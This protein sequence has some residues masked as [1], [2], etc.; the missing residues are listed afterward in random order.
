[1][2]RP[3][4][5]PRTI[6]PR[7]HLIAAGR[8]YPEAWHRVDEM[9]R[10]RGHGLPSWPDW[11]YIPITGTMAIVA[12]DARISVMDMGRLY[13]QRVPDA[14]RLAAL[15]AWRMTQGI[16]RFDPAVYDAVRS[17]PVTGDIPH[18]VLYR[19][20]EWCVYI[21]TPGLT[22]GAAPMA[23]AWA[24]LEHDI[25]TGRAELRL[26]IDTDERAGQAL[27]PALLHLGPW[28][29]AESISRALDVVGVQAMAHGHAPPQGL[30]GVLQPILEPLV[31]LTLY[32]CSQAAEIGDGSRQP[33][34]PAPKRVK[35]GW[36]IFAAEKPTTWD[37]GARMGAALR[38]AYQAT[39][40]GN[41]DTHAG[42]RPH[43]R[44][45]HW[46]GFRSGP[47]LRADGSEIPTEDRA[48]DLRWLPPI[49]V[50]VDAGPIVPTVRPVD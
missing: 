18:Q 24:H 6:R 34:N 39:E 21:E 20:P 4:F 43:V 29:L 32:V 3:K 27:T 47:R 30:R 9:R 40:T 44:R 31:S 45:A 10:E 14:A 38:K 25:N 48:F 2:P 46:H 19:L 17:T 26:L 8:L 50:N 13:P 5:A 12:D 33:G 37:V 42:P 41:G 23:G 22:L 11:C 49:P 7:E 15:G 36:R 35:A 1:M 16:Y 28:S